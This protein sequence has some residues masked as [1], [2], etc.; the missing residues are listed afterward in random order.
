MQM[1]YVN[2]T[3]YITVTNQMCFV[4]HMVKVI[5]MQGT[6]KIQDLSNSLNISFKAF[7]PLGE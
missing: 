5:E 2:D 3:K 6:M 1:R 7:F 4:A